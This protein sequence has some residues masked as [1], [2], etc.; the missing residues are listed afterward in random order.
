[1]IS[2]SLSGC[3][4][5]L[6]LAHVEKIG[7]DHLIGGDECLCL[8]K[9]GFGRYLV[10]EDLRLAP[11]SRSSGRRANTA[12]RRCEAVGGEDFERECEHDR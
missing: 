9:G 11:G 4:P 2:R 6:V 5:L 7:R 10:G 3:G 12:L 8:R 1:M